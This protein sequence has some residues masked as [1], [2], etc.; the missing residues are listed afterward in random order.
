MLWPTL[1]VPFQLLFV[2]RFLGTAEI[3]HK[4]RPRHGVTKVVTMVVPVRLPLALVLLHHLPTLWLDGGA[5]QLRK[6]GVTLLPVEKAESH[7][8]YL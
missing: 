2:G 7:L 1:R 4:E 3:G 8:K 6:F 5:V